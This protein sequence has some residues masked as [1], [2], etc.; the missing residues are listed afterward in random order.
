MNTLQTSH[1]TFLCREPKTPAT[2]TVFFFSL[3]AE[4]SLTLPPFCHPVDSLL[5]NGIRVISTTLPNHENNARPYGIQEIWKRDVDA[6][7]N[8]ISALAAGIKELTTKF[9]PPYGVMGISRGAFISLHIASMLEEVTTAVCFA[10]M[11]TLGGAPQLSTLNLA[12]K[13]HGTRTH[14]FV[15]D[16]DT[17]IGTDNVIALQKSV[18]H[19][20]IEIYPSIGRG[21]HGTPDEIFNK[22]ST[23]MIKN[24]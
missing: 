22:G 5:K 13:L 17:L 10:P 16:N 1:L 4:N 2:K 12:P 3:S 19:S 7:T 6:L 14:F 18:K 24:L 8:F 11:L 21:G 23:W 9:P 20:D 15:G